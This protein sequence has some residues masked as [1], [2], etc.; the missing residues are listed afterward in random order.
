[1]TTQKA[2]SHQK[3]PTWKRGWWCSRTWPHD[4]PCALRARWW[5]LGY[6]SRVPD[7]WWTR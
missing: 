1:M 3:H 6:R 5:N 4:G 7:W 2:D